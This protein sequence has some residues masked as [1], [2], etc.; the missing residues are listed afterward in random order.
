MRDEVRKIQVTSRVTLKR[1]PKKLPLCDVTW[2]KTTHV[3]ILNSGFP[4]H[5]TFVDGQAPCKRAHTFPCISSQSEVPWTTNDTRPVGH[6]TLFPDLWIPQQLIAP[7]RLLPACSP[8][9]TSTRFTIPLRD[10]I[11]VPQHQ[12]ANDHLTPACD[13]L[14]RRQPYH[15]RFRLFQP[16]ALWLCLQ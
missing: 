9:D 10:V 15:Y 12:R 4:V 14:V 13:A 5:L 7:P 6:P 11:A 8:K 2:P 1:A 16:V 3:S